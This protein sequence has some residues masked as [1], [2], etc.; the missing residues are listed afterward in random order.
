VSSLL[1]AVVLAGGLGTRIRAVTGPNRPKAM[2]DVGDRPF[3]DHKIL[4]LRNQGVTEVILLTGHGSGEL[5]AH[6][7]DGSRYG[8]RATC[9]EDGPTLL[10][11]GGALAAAAPHLPP[12]FWLTY[13]DTL[14]DVPM[15]AVQTFFEERSA[16]ALMTVLRNDDRWQP[17]NVTIEGDLVLEYEKPPRPD[18]HRHIDYGMLIL[19]AS[20]LPPPPNGPLDLHPILAALI[21]RRELLAY[22][23]STEFHDIG[24]PEAYADTDALLRGDAP[25]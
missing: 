12:L 25:R 14:L 18:R 17:S 15:A 6:V 5:E 10:G 1:P 8:V 11:T 3:I 2:L 23:V 22:E 9:I 13:G 7:G 20:C 19:P 4:E 16:P 24:T 21:D